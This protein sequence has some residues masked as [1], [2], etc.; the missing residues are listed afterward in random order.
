MAAVWTCNAPTCGRTVDTKT[1]TCPKCGGPMRRVGEAPWRG[2][3][4]ILCGII[5]VGMMGAILAAI[6]GD[7]GEAA[8]TGTSDGFTGTAEQARM[9]LYLFYVIIAFGLLSLVNGVYQLVTGA[10]HKAFIVATLLLVVVLF[11]V[12]YLVMRDLK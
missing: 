7:L 10:Q 9:I 5:L 8:A 4:L 3:V 11:V 1:E 2:W 12:L 6:G